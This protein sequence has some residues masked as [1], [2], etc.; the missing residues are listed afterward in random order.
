MSFELVHLND[1]VSNEDVRADMRRRRA[2]PATQ[3]Q[4]RIFTE[5]AELTDAPDALVVV[6]LGT[7]LVG[8][9]GREYV[10]AVEWTGAGFREVQCAFGPGWFP[11]YRFLAVP[12]GDQSFS[13]Q[14]AAVGQE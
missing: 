7:V 8:E 12:S 4:L 13:R 6:A 1:G 10:P 14:L 5:E 9:D 11:N 2:V 3:E